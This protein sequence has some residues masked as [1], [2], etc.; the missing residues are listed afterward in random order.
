MRRRTVI[1]SILLASLLFLG[2]CSRADQFGEKFTLDTNSNTKRYTLTIGRV[3]SETVMDLLQE[4]SRLITFLNE[5]LDVTVTYSFAENYEQIIDGMSR[6]RYDVVW[7]GP[8][9]YVLSQCASETS[10]NYRPVAQPARPDPTG[11]VSATYRGIIFTNDETNIGSL[12][13][14]K[15]KSMAFV[16]PRSTSGHLFPSARLLDKNINPSEDLKSHKFLYGHD[17]V[18]R[19][20]NKGTFDVGTTYEGARR[21]EMDSNDN[22]DE[23][24]P[25][26]AK[27]SMIPSSP[28]VISDKF[29]NEHPEL[30]RKL[31]ET[32][33]NLHLFPDGQKALEQLNI[34]KYVPASADQYDGVKNVMMKLRKE[35]KLIDAGVC[36]QLGE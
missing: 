36:S 1:T 4:N 33:I 10:A 20:V 34:S 25:V 14:V 31:R 26:L 24:L 16:D 21:Y 8:Y 18:V 28:I 29:R 2:S 27:I 5:K 6:N 13:E 9:A 12:S 11:E 7:L 23:K 32:L 35:L 19:A 15:Q 30:A 17:K 22:L 3:P